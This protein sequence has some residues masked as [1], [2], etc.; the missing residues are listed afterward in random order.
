MIQVL[1]DNMPIDSAQLALQS[2]CPNNKLIYDDVGK[3]GVYVY[4]PKFRLCDVLSTDST[5]VHPAFIRDGKEVDGFWMGKYLSYNSD[6]KAYSLPGKDPGS[7]TILDTTISYNKAKGNK[8]HEVT[9]A[10][11]AAVALWCHKNGTEPKGNNDYG[12]DTTETLYKAVPSMARD[13]TG[14]IQRV[15]TGT[16]P[17]TWSHD[18]TLS[19]IWDLNGNVWEWVS[20]IRLVKGELQVIPYNDAADSTYDLSATS[21]A[22]KAINAKAI[23]WNDLFVTPDDNDTPEDT[24]KLD[25]DG[26]KWKYSTTISNHTTSKNCKFADVSCDIT[27]GD[28]AKLLLQA[29]IML[30][31]T[32]L[33]G[34]G[35]D[36]NYNDDRFHTNNTEIELCM[37][38]GGTWND[39]NY[40]GIF[41]ANMGNQRNNYSSRIGGRSCY[42]EVS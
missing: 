16:G 7:S 3:P 28:E 8:F 30:P 15:A 11:W 22:W 20:G 31:D 10:E 13:N 4:I 40:A 29:L 6:G 39:G 27:I 26:S 34:E 32:E 33:I 5:Q 18:G 17:M 35:I 42:Q 9:A 37:F 25:W 1:Y 2:I 24:V 41:R 36:P 23:S 21:K 14:K 12:K 38:R 19:G